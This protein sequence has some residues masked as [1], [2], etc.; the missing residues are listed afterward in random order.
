MPTMITFR[1]GKVAAIAVLPLLGMACSREQ[2]DWRS[3][4]GADSIEAYSHFLEGHPDSE[5]ATHAR[6]RLLQLSE[7]RDWRR[8][9]A[10]DTADAYRQFLSQH[11][12]GKWAQEARIRIENFSLGSQ[13]RNLPPPVPASGSANAFTAPAQ[14]SVPVRPAPPETPPTHVN[15]QTPPSVGYGAQLGAFSSEA[16]AN[17]QWQQLAARFGSELHGLSPRIIL[18]N[19][20]S[21]HLYRLQVAVADEA[22]A[23]TIC[24]SLKR[25]AQACVPVMP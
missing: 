9:G 6:A 25:Q 10:A 15:S 21:G 11:P 7:D 23:R 12:N 20:P 24:D 4:E 8:A 14:P 22:Q 5:L 18:A 19:T 13:P 17:S 2:Q 16:G 3:A 1:A